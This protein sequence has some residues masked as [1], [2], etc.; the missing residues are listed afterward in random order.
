LEEAHVLLLNNGS[1]VVGVET[2]KNLVLPGV[3]KFTIVDANLVIESDLRV[4]FF[5]E[6]SSLGKSR[7]AETCRLLEEL[8]PEVQGHAVHE[9]RQH[10]ALATNMLLMAFLGCGKLHIQNVPLRLQPHLH[11]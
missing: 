10:G 11:R 5:L 2:L 9:V 4:N 1:G 8:N 3:G 7:A 6:D